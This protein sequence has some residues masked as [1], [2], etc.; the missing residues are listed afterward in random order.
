MD[1][2]PLGPWGMIP[3]DEGREVGQGEEA[4]QESQRE[5]TEPLWAWARRLR[6]H[7]SLHQRRSQT[8]VWGTLH[9]QTARQ[10]GAGAAAGSSGTTLRTRCWSCHQ[11]RVLEKLSG[12]QPAPSSGTAPGGGPALKKTRESSME[13]ACC[14]GCYSTL[15]PKMCW[16]LFCWGAAESPG[17]GAVLCIV[18]GCQV[19]PGNPAFLPV[20]G[21][22]PR[23]ASG[24]CSSG[25]P[26]L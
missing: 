13:V 17:R 23:G 10:K 7:H 26:H 12:S 16:S 14:W 3:K 8:G 5:H 2:G 20:L 11:P 24:T 21:L 1:R 22:P 25:P 6:C 9:I 19:G 18:Q 4:E 15:P